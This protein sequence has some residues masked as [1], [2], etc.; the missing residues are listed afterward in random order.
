MTIL[1]FVWSLSPAYIRGIR[2]KH[3]QEDVQEHS[4]YRSA[5]KR[6]TA[7]THR[8]THKRI[9]SKHLQERTQ[10]YPHQAH[11]LWCT[12][13]H[14][15]S[16]HRLAHIQEDAQISYITLNKAFFVRALAPYKVI[17][18]N[19][20]K[21][22]TEH[23]TT[24]TPEKELP[25][26]VTSIHQYHTHIHISVHTRTYA[27]A[28]CV[29]LVSLRTL[30]WKDLFSFTQFC[31]CYLVVFTFPRRWYF[32]IL[33][34]WHEKVCSLFLFLVCCRPKDTNDQQLPRATL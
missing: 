32:F 11:T 31:H 19:E 27:L 2:G 8:K 15:A 30:F 25:M 23:P 18:S 12:R 33:H 24:L 21:Y 4:L 14:T 9:H 20:I 3:T 22:L 13:G 34:F 26:S 7:S 17:D 5:H 10:V 6:T 29:S 1:A 16:T 28:N